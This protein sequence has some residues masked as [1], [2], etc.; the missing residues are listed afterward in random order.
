[1]NAGSLAKKLEVKVAA[2]VREVH[3]WRE[4]EDY[5]HAVYDEA[6]DYK[7]RILEFFHKA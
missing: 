7:E 6:P 5:G 1:M 2:A 4:V 3:D